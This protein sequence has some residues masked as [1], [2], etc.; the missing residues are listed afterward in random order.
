M[1]T[2]FL[3]TERSEFPLKASFEPILLLCHP[4]RP[5]SFSSSKL[6]LLDFRLNQRFIFSLFK[7]GI[8]HWKYE[9]KNHHK[10]A[11]IDV[12]FRTPTLAKFS[13]KPPKK[14]LIQFCFFPICHNWL[15]SFS[16]EGQKGENDTDNNFR[17]FFAPIFRKKASFSTET[18][19]LTELFFGLGNKKQGFF[20][21]AEMPG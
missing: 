9:L 8:T 11:N 1:F 3:F 19:T 14:I 16:L 17:I 2:G 18:E 10:L 20:S 7:Q 15:I 6:P 13:K 5:C 12:L 4:A 21:F